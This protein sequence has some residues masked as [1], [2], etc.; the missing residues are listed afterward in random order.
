VSFRPTSFVGVRGS[1]EERKRFLRREKAHCGRAPSSCPF[2][3]EFQRLRL[4]C[5]LLLLRA[6]N[7][8]AGG[9]SRRGRAAA[10]LGPCLS[11]SWSSGS[12]HALEPRLR[13]QPLEDLTGFGQQRLCLGRTDLLGEPLAMLQLRDSE[14]E[15]QR[16]L[17]EESGRP[18]E[19]ALRLVGI[20]LP[21]RD[22][23]A[24][25]RALS[26]QELGCC[27]CLEVLPQR[28][29]L[30]PG[31][32]A[33]TGDRPASSGVAPGRHGFG[34]DHQVDPRVLVGIHE[35]KRNEN[36]LNAATAPCTRPCR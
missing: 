33:T 6:C 2:T 28:G 24:E 1:H 11:W 13:S 15:E 21:C 19:A 23:R 29:I 20:T 22:L 17:A 31:S 30:P 14:V 25:A 9:G 26:L 5:A 34:V 35:F 10:A 3:H 36:G 18:L 7:E 32:T 16:Q 27:S 12:L 8:M 4:R